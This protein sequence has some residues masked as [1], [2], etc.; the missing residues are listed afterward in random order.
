MVV[1]RTRDS[2]VP[3]DQLALWLTL[4][5][6]SEDVAIGELPLSWNFMPGLALELEPGIAQVHD[7]CFDGISILHLAACKR[8]PW[9]LHRIAAALEEAG[10]ASPW[11]LPGPACGV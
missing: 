6:A 3:N 2:F 11:P 5:E 10:V 4:W 8:E 7:S 9:A 1:G